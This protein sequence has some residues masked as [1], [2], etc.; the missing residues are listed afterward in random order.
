M[1]SLGKV[2]ARYAVPAMLPF[3]SELALSQTLQRQIDIDLES[4]PDASQYEIKATSTNNA[5][6]AS[7]SYIVPKNSFSKRLPLGKWKL[8]MRSYDQRGI[9]GR[10]EPISEI[11]LK[12]K[13][14]TLIEPSA[15][16]VFRTQPDKNITMNFRWDVFDEE[17]TFS[18]EIKAVTT[19]ETVISKEIKGGS[20]QVNLKQGTYTWRVESKPPDDIKVDGNDP[21]LSDFMISAGQLQKPVIKKLA[22]NPPEIIEWN[23]HKY[24]TSFDVKMERFKDLHGRPIKPPVQ[25]VFRNIGTTSES[26]PQKLEPG[27][28]RFIVLAKADGFED[29][30]PQ[31][32]TF[33]IPFGYSELK[34]ETT[35]K[36]AKKI[37]QGPRHTPVDF[38][39][40]SMGPVL[41][42]YSFQSSGGQKFELTSATVT[43]IAADANK[44]LTKGE[45]SAW[46]AEFRARQTN[47][48]LF[49][50]N[51]PQKSDQKKVTVADRRLALL[52]RRRKIID[53]VG[54][55]VIV[56]VGSH[57]YT[58]LIQ[59]QRTSLIYPLEGQLI[60]LYLGGALDWQLKSASH[61]VFDLTFHPVG[62]SIGISADQTWQYTASA[63]Y[64]HQSFHNRS[65]YSL[66]LE[67]FRSRVN[68]H[69][70]RFSGDA[71]TISNWY[72][73]GIGL[74]FKI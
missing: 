45:T 23:T 58:Y 22:K 20:T 34:P 7:L 68:T 25:V 13:P 37:A 63:R 32:T 55:D 14:A 49:E 61:A 74:A 72:R 24:A 57:H 26:I 67:N 27:T 11:D 6:S 50:N 42:N 1:T 52:A 2:L 73:A 5:E 65:F 71:Q 4:V 30:I 8:E 59:D 15:K 28:Y 48:Y 69:S 43:A 54:L 19:G 64:I 40:G 66:S 17:A 21:N 60:E 12:F 62:T 35:P 33:R 44:W 56:G 51:G 53:R 10:W 31:Q 41:W 46:A 3:F 38:L 29:S 16:S 39:Q 70:E 47:I 36:A 9:A 18:L